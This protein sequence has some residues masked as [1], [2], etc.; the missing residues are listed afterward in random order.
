MFCG[1]GPGPFSGSSSPIFGLGTKYKGGIGE[2]VAIDFS[3]SGRWRADLLGLGQNSPKNVRAMTDTAQE[4]W[5]KKKI[6]RLVKALVAETEN[7]I[8][9]GPA[10]Q[11]VNWK[12]WRELESQQAFW[13]I[14]NLNNKDSR[15]GRV[16]RA[17]KKA[18]FDVP[19]IKELSKLA[20]E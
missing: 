19:D 6:D 14:C 17:F 3:R 1:L 18:G 13:E 2:R 4:K 20:M 9:K 10:D 7:W 12:V 15:V 8:R 5:T 16:L 11:S